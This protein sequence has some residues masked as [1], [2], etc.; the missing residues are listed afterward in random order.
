MKKE[1]IRGALSLCHR[2]GRITLGSYLVA[3]EIKLGRAALVLLAED[4]A[5]NTEKKVLPVAARAGVR[6]ER[7]P[8]T[9]KEL[10]EVLGREAGV[11]CV[12]VPQDIVNLVL[13]SM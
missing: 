11:T 2:A 3:E 10:G 5:A 1:K 9:K 4:A 7:I 6:A 8:L 12:S 13:T